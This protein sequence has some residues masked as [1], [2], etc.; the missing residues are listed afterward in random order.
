[1][2]A[3]RGGR[4]FRPLSLVLEQRGKGQARQIIEHADKIANQVAAL[5]EIQQL[6]EQSTGALADKILRILTK[7][8]IHQ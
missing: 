2:I 8:G 5:T 1:V 7:H 3:A 4:T 6:A